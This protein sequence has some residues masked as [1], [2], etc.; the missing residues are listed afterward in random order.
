MFNEYVNSGEYF[1]D[2][3]KW[4]SNKYIV[5]LAHRSTLFGIVLLLIL[6][7]I[8]LAININSL[9]PLE[10]SLKY[11]IS[12][13]GDQDQNAIVT[14]ADAIPNAPLASV[15]KIMLE[16]YVIKR[17]RYDY[18]N[19]QDQMQYIHN[20]STRTT[21]SQFYNYLNID[22]PNSPVL[23]YQDELKRNIIITSTKFL[24][25]SHAQISF[26]S[27]AVADGKVFENLSWV[28]DIAFDS[29]QINLSAPSNSKFHFI[30]TDYKL[31]LVGE[32][33]A[34]N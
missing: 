25:N 5:P 31:K 4:Y 27:K 1:K 34:K 20:T 6:L 2:A 9:L 8:M 13:Q 3:R 11:I 32:N 21:F 7:L 24:D 23:R 14:K 28:A 19:L 33:H 10:R 17:E 29:D 30:I 16:D 22:N 26:I 12:V 18:N 15:L